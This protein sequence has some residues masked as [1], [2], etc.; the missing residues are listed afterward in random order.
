MWGRRRRRT[1][2]TTTRTTKTAM[3]S[4]LT[5]S[6]IVV[7]LLANCLHFAKGR[8]SLSKRRRPFRSSCCFVDLFCYRACF[9]IGGRHFNFVR[10]RSMETGTQRTLRELIS[11]SH[12]LQAD[13]KTQT[14]SSRFV[15]L[16]TF[17]VNV[18]THCVTG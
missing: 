2:T 15:M 12:S 17:S 9:G 8:P 7:L 6:L 11:L 10:K 1:T 18:I 14:Q 4:T 16:L 5:V 13:G 3:N